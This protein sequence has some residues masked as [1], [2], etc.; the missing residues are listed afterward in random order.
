MRKSI[1]SRSKWITEER[2]RTARR[3]L[4][5]GWWM[6]SGRFLIQ[7]QPEV[8]R[9]HTDRGTALWTAIDPD[10]RLISGHMMRTMIDLYTS[11]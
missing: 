6:R 9:R 8:A 5:L 11:V 10:V 3:T 7:D 4:P 1:E 2:Q